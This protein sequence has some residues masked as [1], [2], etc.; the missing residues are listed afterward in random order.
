V[1]YSRQPRCEE[2]AEAVLLPKLKNSKVS[3][4]LTDLH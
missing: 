2:S 3:Q 1:N 4:Q